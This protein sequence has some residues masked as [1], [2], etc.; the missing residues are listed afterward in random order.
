MAGKEIK[1]RE[2]NTLIEAGQKL[3]REELIIW[4]WSLLKAK[5]TG[6]GKE[7]LSDE[8]IERYKKERKLPIMSSEIDLDELKE[9]FPNIFNGWKLSYY[10]KLLKGMEEKIAFEVNLEQYL[11][12]LEAN[13]YSYVIEQLDIPK[14]PSKVL[15]YGISVIMSVTLLEEGKLKVVFSPYVTPLLLE[16]KRWYTT[17]DFL[18][19]LKLSSKHSVVLYRL[20]K[21]KLGLK[22]N[23]FVL[24]VEDLNKIFGV[25]YKSWK[26]LRE[27]VID[28][29]VKD[30]TKNT[31]YKIEYETIRKGKGGKVVKVRF[32]VKESKTLPG[33]SIYEIL[34]EVSKEISTPE[35]LAEALLSLRRVN[36]AVALW[37][38]LHYPEGEAKYFAWQTILTAEDNKKIKLPD[39]Y[40]LSLITQKDSQHQWLLDQRTKDLIGR[41][42]KKIAEELLKKK[43]IKEEID[44]LFEEIVSTYRFLPRKGKVEVLK[45]YGGKEKFQETLKEL[46]ENLNEEELRKILDMVKEIA[47]KYKDELGELIF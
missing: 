25:K 17:Y 45:A 38:L 31:R 46:K 43:R 21:E 35:E 37:F 36:P 42:L 30:V 26:P 29:A 28:P 14:Q 44:K 6:G 8:E 19:L 32:I 24:T 16:L 15:Y 12:T 33:L 5:P 4:T 39:R 7:R 18:D 47:D 41:E 13:G 27:N 22:Q 34:K 10:K 20:I 23:P 3:S 40:L 1:I 2:P 11:K 9:L